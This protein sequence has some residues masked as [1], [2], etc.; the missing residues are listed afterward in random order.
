MANNIIS[1]IEKL[2]SKTEEGKIVWKSVSVNNLRWTRQDGNSLFTVTLQKQIPTFNFQN[3]ANRGIYSL[4]IQSTNPNEIILQVNTSM[5]ATLFNSLDKL[6][7]FALNSSRTN[8]AN[9]IDKL[10]DDL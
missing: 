4:T 6:Y 9:I 2:I 3:T 10:L 5:D 7:M 8:S 1:Q